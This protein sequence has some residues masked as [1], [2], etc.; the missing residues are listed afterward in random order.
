MEITL[1]SC[2]TGSPDP[3]CGGLISDNYD[4]SVMNGATV[5]MALS[6][7]TPVTLTSDNPAPAFW[8]GRPGAA[9]IGSFYSNPESVENQPSNSR[10]AACAAGWSCL[11]TVNATN[12]PVSLC[13]EAAVELDSTWEFDFSSV[14]PPP[15]G[16]ASRLF[17]AVDYPDTV[18]NLKG[19]DCNFE[20]DGVT[21]C[22]Q[23]SDCS[24][25]PGAVCGFGLGRVSSCGKIIPSF[26]HISIKF[27][28]FWQDYSIFDRINLLRFKY[29]L[30]ENV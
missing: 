15:E 4:L 25:S 17:T 20:K 24:G 23:D 30:K 13:V 8:C 11:D 21:P 9:Q 28:R 5:P 19:A 29:L 10:S 2:P 1:S 26:C 12:D 3:T 14:P 7:D 22:T 18:K 16:D 27:L 6:P